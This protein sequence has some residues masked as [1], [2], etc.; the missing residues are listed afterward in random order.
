VILH[1]VNIAGVV[2]GTIIGIILH[3]FQRTILGGI[4]GFVIMLSLYYLGKWLIRLRMKAKNSYSI[5][6]ALGF[7]DVNFSGVLGLLLGWP[8]IIAGLIIT[9]LA[10]GIVS[11]IYLCIM[12]STKRYHTNLAIPYGPFLALSAVILLYL[13]PIT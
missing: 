9:I 8:G 5:E 6:E 7:G 12:L 13:L 2:I 10:A 1:Q 4:A 11:F 3:G